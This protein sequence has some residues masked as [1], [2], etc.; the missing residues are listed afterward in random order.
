MTTRIPEEGDARFIFDAQDGHAD[1]AIVNRDLSRDDGLETAITVSL[2]SNKR[3]EEDDELPDA[4]GTR[5]GWFGDALLTNGDTIGSKLWLLSRSKFNDDLLN[6]AQQFSLEALQWMIDD[7]VAGEINVTVERVMVNAFVDIAGVT[8]VD[9]SAMKITV[10][11][12]RPDNGE[13]VFFPYF[14]NWKNQVA[15]RA[16]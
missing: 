2:F 3:A 14:Y 7:G 10:E 4:D 6:D 13:S 1:V 11:I 16:A 9:Q 8:K 12:V 5:E 15:R